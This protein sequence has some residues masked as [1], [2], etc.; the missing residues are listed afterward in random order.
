M[1]FAGMFFDDFQF[2]WFVVFFLFNSLLMYNAVIH[3]NIDMDVSCCPL[4]QM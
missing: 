3:S 4:I 1:Q 2:Q